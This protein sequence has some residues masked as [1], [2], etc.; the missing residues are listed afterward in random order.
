[1]VG[2][3]GIRKERKE[4][5]GLVCF[6]TTEMNKT[7][8]HITLLLLLRLLVRVV[9]ICIHMVLL[10]RPGTL[11]STEQDVYICLQHISCKTLW[12]ARAACQ[13]GE[14]PG[15]R[16]RLRLHSTWR[17]KGSGHIE[18]EGSSPAFADNWVS[19]K[20]NSGKIPLG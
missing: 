13:P 1:M 10:A 4:K 12:I 17:A 18:E 16:N 8:A 3:D 19:G 2:G 15:L 9:R 7:T 20:I 6:A 5:A 11:N 14:S